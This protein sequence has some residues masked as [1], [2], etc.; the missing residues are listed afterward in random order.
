MLRCIAAR[1]VVNQLGALGGEA[2]EVVCLCAYRRLVMVWDVWL[3]EVEVAR[4]LLCK[5][6]EVAAV[7]KRGRGHSQQ[8]PSRPRRRLMI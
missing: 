5:R 1:P 4:W 8:R 6:V 7:V 2:L 3:Y